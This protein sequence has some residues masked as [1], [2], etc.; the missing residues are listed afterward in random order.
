MK[1]LANAAMALA[2]SIPATAMAATDGTLGPTS[3]GIFGATLTINDSNVTHV[4]IL[5]LDDIAFGTVD[6]AVGEIPN[7]LAS[8]D[9]WVCLKRSN[10]GLVRLTV[11]QTIAGV[12]GFGMISSI[13]S[14]GDGILDRVPIALLLTD[15]A[16]RREEIL[17]NGEA[18]PPFA[19]SPASCTTASSGTNNAHKLVLVLPAQS[20]ALPGNYSATF[21]ALLAPD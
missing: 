6:A 20:D 14:N 19:P 4:Q 12:P 16:G 15:V 2:L 13:D 18:L 11:S 8:G 3:T 1:F 9:N 17:A 10:P 21:V 5:G 7:P